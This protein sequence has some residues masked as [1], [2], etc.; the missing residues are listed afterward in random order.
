MRRT[1]VLIAENPASEK[2]IEG[3]CPPLEPADGTR[4]HEGLIL[5]SL[6][7]FGSV[8]DSELVVSYAPASAIDFFSCTNSK[9]DTFIL[10]TETDR[11]KGIDGVFQ[12]LCDH[13][14]S[15]IAMGSDSPTLPARCVELAFDSLASGSVDLVL[16]PVESGGCYLIG[17]NEHRP[18][19]LAN[20]EWNADLVKSLVERAASLDMGWYLLPEWYSVERSSDLAHLKAELFDQWA[21]NPSAPITKALLGELKTA[22]KV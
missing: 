12:E 2:S 11:I 6:R 8:P 22:G 10:R 17:V 3:L 19:L 9:A 20:I 16:G 15:V 7:K 13:D 1:I 5:D 18:E 14:R 4:L 21:T